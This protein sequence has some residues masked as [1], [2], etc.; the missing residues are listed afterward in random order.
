M[1]IRMTERE[2]ADYCAARNLFATIQ[3]GNGNVESLQKKK[4]SKY[5]NRKVF[6]YSTGAAS[7]VKDTR[8]GTLIAVYDSEKEYRRHGELKLLERQGLI[9]GLCRQVELR[10]QD[11]CE[12]WGKKVNAVNY[13]A[14]FCYVE[15]GKEIVEDV[16]G[17]DEK[18]GKYIMTKDFKLKWKLLQYRYP[19]KHFRVY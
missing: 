9:S 4:A 3:A 18:T 8:L 11:A 1:T 7:P 13:I 12:R 10:I 2:F 15:D 14:D 16:K 19:E 17:F 5:R 6:L